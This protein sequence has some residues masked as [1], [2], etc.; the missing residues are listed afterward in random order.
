MT[1]HIQYSDKYQDDEYEYR[2]VILPNNIYKLI[3]RGRLLSDKE[4]RDIGIQQSR[5]WIHYALWKPEPH[6]LLFRRLLTKTNG[7]SGTSSIGS[8]SI[9]SSNLCKLTKEDE[10]VINNKIINK[11]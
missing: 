5:G 10:D 2:H 7:T 9:G 11:C 8:G 3:P 6:I 1:T 4:W